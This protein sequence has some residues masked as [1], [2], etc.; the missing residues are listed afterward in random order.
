MEEQAAS[1]P[2]Q[3]L[4]ELAQTPAPAA[5]P[6]AKKPTPAR[7]VQQASNQV[8][9]LRQAET[10][11]QLQNQVKLLETQSL[12][13]GKVF[14]ATM[15]TLITSAFALVAAL[16]WNSAIQE[17]F[18]ELFHTSESAGVISRFA[19]AI[20]ITLI[21]VIVIWYLTRLNKR[22]GARSL[23]GEIP[24]TSEGGKKEESKK[25]D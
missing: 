11:K 14:L 13:G 20:L 16:A 23:I 3:T 5:K 19:Y 12:E 8:E 4:A 24:H 17:L 6:G 9:L 1:A 10:I 25:D 21:V 2:P 15:T 18:N 22:L 7:L